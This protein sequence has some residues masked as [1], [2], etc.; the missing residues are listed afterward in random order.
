MGYYFEN[1]AMKK[2][3]LLI[4]VALVAC[5]ACTKSLP[6]RMN[7]LAD[8][9]VENADKYTQEEW[10]KMASEFDTLLNEY[11]EN[12]DSFTEEERSEINRAMGKFAKAATVHGV[13]QV[14]KSLGAFMSGFSGKVDNF[15][16]QLSGFLE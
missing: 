3:L 14:S 10:N 13:T 9:I 15:F 7:R 11:K 4:V 12:Y 1:R 2:I 8:K 16:D 6:A 5:V